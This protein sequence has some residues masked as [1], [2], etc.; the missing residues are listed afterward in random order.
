MNGII[1]IEEAWKQVSQH[2]LNAVWKVWSEA[3]AESELENNPVRNV[4]VNMAQQLN[5][6]QVDAE[7]VQALLNSYDD[8]LTNEELQELREQNLVQEDADS[9]ITKDVP[10]EIILTT[11]ILSDYLSE[12]YHSVEVLIENDQ[13]LERSCAVKRNV[14]N[15]LK[16]YNE[17][18]RDKKKKAKQSTLD[19]F[20]SKD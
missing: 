6:T 16:C 10:P 13:D 3:V 15:A 12:V 11:K 14:L 18:L 20:L 2:C 9:D 19:S 7:D 4:L 8:P 1:S 17:M 5:F